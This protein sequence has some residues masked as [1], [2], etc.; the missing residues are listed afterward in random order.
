[1]LLHIL[2]KDLKRKR[3][4]N[5]IL[6]LFIVLVTVFLASSVNNLITITG[7]VDFFLETAKTADYLIV[8]GSE[9]PKTP[10]DEFLEKCEYVTEYEVNDAYTLMDENIEIV[11]CAQDM[12]KTDYEKGNTLSLFPVPEN[13]AKVFDESGEELC[14]RTGELAMPK[15]QAE[16]NN[17]QAGDIIKIN[18]DGREKEFTIRAIV[19]DAIFGTSHMGYKRLFISK[20][21]YIELVGETS[22][23]HT[24]LYNVNCSDEKEFLK[25]YRKNNF[26]VFS[27]LDKATVKMCYIFDMLLSGILI[28]V[29]ICLILISFLILRFTIVFT[30]QEDYKEIGI[31]KAIGITDM[32][33]KG[34]Y[35]IKYLAIA[36]AGSVIGLIFSFPFGR[37]LIS[38]SIQN[39]MVSDIN[40]NIGINLLC[41][42][43]IIAIIS[44]FCFLS[45]GKVSRFTAV[46]AIRKGGNGERYR[47]KNL[48][49]LYKRKKMLPAVYMACN[50][51]ISN[52]KRYLVLAAVFC[53]GTLLI[54]LPLKAVHTLQDEGIIRL[55]GLQSSSVFIETGDL[56]KFL[57]QKD[58]SG[59]SAYIE[60]I[61]E[62]LRQEGLDT[63]AW[64]ELGYTISCYGNDPSQKFS[65]YTQ[66]QIGKDE[67]DYEV[68]EGKVPVFPNEIMLTEKTAQEL[69][70]GIGDAVYLEFS[71][72]VKEFIVTGTYQS[73]M[74]MGNGLRVGKGAEL[75]DSYL[76]G[77]FG[78]QADI[79]TDL[80]SSELVEKMQHLLPD[81][82]IKSGKEYIREIIGISDQMDDLIWLI[83][84]TVLLINILI[85]LLTMKSLITRERGEIAMLKSIGF[86]ERTIKGWQCTR[87][88]L[89]LISS[90]LLGTVLSH[91]LAPVTIGPVFAMMGATSI[92]LVTN[93]LEAY[94]VYPLILLLVT[95]ITSYLCAFEIKKV[96]LKE[97]NT[98]E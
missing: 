13:F 47:V 45:T 3:T 90:I 11:K 94:V 6:F 30:L 36:L 40:G 16:K 46:E 53:I 79:K 1:M 95:G 27:M 9:E 10:I 34:I 93:S 97:I 17:L 81:Y 59:I 15:I 37:L 85:T 38:K 25:E 76:S 98:L 29:S 83:T 33:I 70:V 51:V 67:D 63:D 87:I 31:M 4:M 7:A 18:C 61:E 50:D 91:F 68:I 41:A 12:G 88:L 75:P 58:R 89:V 78:L 2:K 64:V 44:L 43:G 8:V 48:L 77:F 62:E 39:I 60:R 82:T 66:Q 32:G 55:F 69:G 24:L 21:D 14:L 42:L 73:M 52:T 26:E 20:E 74:N 84:V 54:L 5:M 96:D 80:N 92:K 49:K 56:E 65:Y 23:F 19:K 57:G 28:V 72:E 71:T 86:A 35:L 22:S